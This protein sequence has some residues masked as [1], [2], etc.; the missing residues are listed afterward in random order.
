VSAELANPNEPET[1]KK[2]ETN[3]RSLDRLLIIPGMQLKFL[4]YVAYSGLGLAICFTWSIYL[5]ISQNYSILLNYSQA[6]AHTYSQLEPSYQNLLFFLF[7]SSFT[8]VLIIVIMAFF[9]SHKIAGPVFQINS[10]IKKALDGDPSSRVQLR[11]TDELHFLA[12]SV[13]QLLDRQNTK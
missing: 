2:S 10:A 1:S 11:P 7:L 6:D 12:E 4:S 3:R 9:F 5:F 13:N 8:F